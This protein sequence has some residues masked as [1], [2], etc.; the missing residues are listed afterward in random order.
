M[1]SLHHNGQERIGQ[2]EILLFIKELGRLIN[3][4]Q[5]CMELDIRAQ[6]YSEILLLSH[7][8]DSCS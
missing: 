1:E 8:L 5:A 2:N 3:D 4:Y 6:I 7:I